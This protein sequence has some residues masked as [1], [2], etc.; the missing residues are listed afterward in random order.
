MKLQKDNSNHSK[1]WRSAA[2]SLV[3]V[4][5]ALLRGF[6][7]SDSSALT[8]YSICSFKY[9]EH[10]DHCHCLKHP[11]LIQSHREKSSTTCWCLKNH[12]RYNSQLKLKNSQMYSLGTSFCSFQEGLCVGWIPSH[13]TTPP[14]F[15]LGAAEARG[16]QTEQ[17][18]RLNCV[19]MCDWLCY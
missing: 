13:P 1:S 7:L 17:H 9:G 4:S 18:N 10:C 14:G 3:L 16:L 12:G 5:S 11:V 2:Y 15:L 8:F 6:V 19:L